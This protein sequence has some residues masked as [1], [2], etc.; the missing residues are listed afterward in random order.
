[1]HET[2][3]EVV[4]V[5][6]RNRVDGGQAVML[7]LAVAVVIVVVAM[8]AARFGARVVHREQAQAAADAAALAGV[9]GGRPGAARVASANHGTLVSFEA[10]GDDVVV[11]VTVAGERAT[12]RATRAP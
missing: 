5:R 12:A 7:V 4:P 2:T 6:A 3:Q 10:R 8:A 9:D 1:M 11:V